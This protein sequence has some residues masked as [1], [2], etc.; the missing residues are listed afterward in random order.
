MW[1]KAYLEIVFPQSRLLRDRLLQIE[2]QGCEVTPQTSSFV[3]IL[4]RTF[5]FKLGVD[6][7]ER[8]ITCSVFHGKLLSPFVRSN[9]VV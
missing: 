2:T 8:Q 7:L 4:A 5:F 3:S 1:Q 9:G 6:L